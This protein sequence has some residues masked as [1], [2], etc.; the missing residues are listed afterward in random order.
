MTV[1]ME[2]K[3]W[4]PFVRE[5]TE[6]LLEALEQELTID[7]VKVSP[8]AGS[9]DRWELS[10]SWFILPRCGLDDLDIGDYIELEADFEDDRSALIR[11]DVHPL[12]DDQVGV[13][14]ELLEVC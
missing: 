2:V 13:Q 11:A 7:R 12:N 14:L 8:E 4:S 6:R 5:F 3:R 10:N 9:G 1:S